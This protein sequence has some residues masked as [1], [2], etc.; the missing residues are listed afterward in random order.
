MNEKK[1]KSFL[2]NGFA[3]PA[4][5][6]SPAE[7]EEVPETGEEAFED[8]E[9]QLPQQDPQLE[10]R[11][12]SIEEELLK[13]RY[14]LEDL[15]D[16]EPPAPAPQVD[17]APYLTTREQMKAVQ[18]S[19]E[20]KEVEVSNKTLTA[21]MEQIAVM[22][23]DFFRLCQ[24]MRERIGEMTPEDVLSSFEAYEVDMEN[25][26]RDGGVYIGPF[27]YE[28][29]NTIH[30]RI[31]GVIETDD[32]EKDGTIAERHTE[33]YK[34][35]KRVILKEKVSVYKYVAPAA[36]TPSET[37]SETASEDSVEEQE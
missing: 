14:I 22:R 27:E 4:E 31:V 29:L 18:A 5:E 20:R 13:M 34:L 24:S 33:G 17:L 16:R 28:R 15:K 35:G 12:D 10:Q 25:I 30:Q 23:E 1:I 37:D 6:E 7:A 26:L 32:R 9:E 21:A 3:A 8:E 11:L 36:E 2:I 19:V